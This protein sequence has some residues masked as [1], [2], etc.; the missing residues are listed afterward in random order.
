MHYPF[1]RIFLLFSLISLG[2]LGAIGVNH[3]Y[4][5]YKQ[6]VH[7][8]LVRRALVDPVKVFQIGFS[9]CGTTTLA[10][11]FSVNGVATVHHDFGYLAKTMQKNIKAGEVDYRVP[12]YK[13]VI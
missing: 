10:R 9:K 13:E 12:F 2:L 11:F 4:G 7:Y 1:K 6:A 3:I 5:I 8:K